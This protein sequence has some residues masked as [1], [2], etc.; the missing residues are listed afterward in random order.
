MGEHLLEDRLEMGKW[1]VAQHGG[2]CSKLG[3][4]RRSRRLL[5]FGTIRVDA[6]AVAQ[7]R[8]RASSSAHTQRATRSMVASYNWRPCWGVIAIEFAR[9][10]WY[11]THMP[12]GAAF[13]AQSSY[14]ARVH[15]PNTQDLNFRLA[16]TA[17]SY[18]YA[19][20]RSFRLKECA[21]VRVVSLEGNAKNR[22]DLQRR[23]C[24]A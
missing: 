5:H 14:G 2:L 1:R 24:V 21:L 23:V 17:S 18:H 4:G 9:L 16:H 8:A 13:R 3:D 12:L 11:R 10:A 22:S 6:I 20:C 7:S 15:R 19:T